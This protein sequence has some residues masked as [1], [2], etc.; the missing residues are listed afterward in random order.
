MDDNYS[1]VMPFLDDSESFTNG[2][3]VGQLWESFK[4]NGCPESICVH[5]KNVEQMRLV[6]AHYNHDMDIMKTDYEEWTQVTFTQK[7]KPGL[8][9]V[10]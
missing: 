9:L 10:K 1:L 4:I 7:I 3:E 2:F 6:A 8:R 5:T